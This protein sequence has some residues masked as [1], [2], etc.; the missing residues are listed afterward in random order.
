[1]CY[2]SLKTNIPQDTHTSAVAQTIYKLLCTIL[3]ILLLSKLRVFFFPFSSNRK[4]RNTLKSNN[5][6]LPQNCIALI[7][8]QVIL[9]CSVTHQGTFFFKGERVI[10][11]KLETLETI[12][13]ATEMA[14]PLSLAA[15][16]P[17]GLARGIL[18]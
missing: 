6:R 16:P 17:Y 14:T 5:F 15:P 13:F 12:D 8:P 3:N 7:L 4:R 2:L 10:A 1:M 9:P 11:L 18:S